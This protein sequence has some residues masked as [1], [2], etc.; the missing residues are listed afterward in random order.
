MQSRDNALKLLLNQH[1]KEKMAESV[2]V[3]TSTQ[4]SSSVLDTAT[5]R[6]RHTGGEED[7]RHRSFT[8]SSDNN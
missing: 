4:C 6:Q 7:G 2:P 8:K 5:T 3:D 1:L